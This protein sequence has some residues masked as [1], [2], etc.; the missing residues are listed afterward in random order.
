MSHE[1][2]VLEMPVKRPSIDILTIGAGGGSIGWVDG[3]EQFR[4][5][6]RSAGAF[7]GPACYAA[8]AKSRPS[9]MP[10]WC[11]AYLARRNRSA[12]RSASTPTSP[13]GPARR[14]GRKLGMSALEAAW[15]IRQI[16]NAAMAGATRAVSIGRGHDPRDFSLIAFGGAGPMHGVD[17]AAELEIPNVL[18]PAVPGCLSA[19]GLVVSDVT[20]DYVT[21]HVAPI[22]DTLHP[23]LERIL[24][25]SPP[26]HMRSWRTKR[27]RQAVRTLSILDMRYIGEQ[28]SVS[29]PV[30]A[31]DATGLPRPRRN[32]T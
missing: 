26:A 12:A 4:V 8:A 15:G 9:P 32:S 13:T 17:I 6:P 14:L 20:H 10:I 3:A 19:I 11:W 22:S 1:R 5:G 21:T 7:P 24:P 31:N 28:W 2:Q 18:V 23:Q 30:E 27:S 16:V 25:S 29:V